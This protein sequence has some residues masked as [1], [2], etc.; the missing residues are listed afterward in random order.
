M[1][2]YVKCKE[3]SLI[4]K[5]KLNMVELKANYMGKLETLVAGDV[6]HRMNTLNICGNVNLLQLNLE[7]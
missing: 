7:K 6:E 3:G 1:K 4:L 2:E 5:V